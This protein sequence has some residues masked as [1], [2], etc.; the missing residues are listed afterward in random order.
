MKYNPSATTYK[1]EKY[2]NELVRTKESCRSVKEKCQS[3]E[4]R[5]MYCHYEQ[6]YEILSPTRP[7]AKMKN[8]LMGHNVKE[9]QLQLLTDFIFDRRRS[10]GED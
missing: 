8:I 7:P 2:L 3:H 10:S 5:N 9:S 6:L 4:F 1:N